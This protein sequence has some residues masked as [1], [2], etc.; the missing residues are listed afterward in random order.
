MV[1]ACGLWSAIDLVGFREWRNYV[2]STLSTM[3]VFVLRGLARRLVAIAGLVAVLPVAALPFQE[4]LVEYPIRGVRA[5]RPSRPPRPS[6]P[7][8]GPRMSPGCTVTR[9]RRRQRRHQSRQTIAAS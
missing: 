1:P 9:A 6:T 3:A 8:C 4:I 2:R 7:R 5:L